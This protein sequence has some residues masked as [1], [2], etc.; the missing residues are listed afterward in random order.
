M[1]DLISERVGGEVVECNDE[2]FAEAINLIKAEE[3]VW[4]EDLY[5]DRGKWMDGWETRR[6]REPGHDWCVISLGIPGRVRRVTVDT[7]FFTGNY[8]EEFSLDVSPGNDVWSELVPRT[9]LEGDARATFEVESPY[10]VAA[11]RLNIYPD[12]GVARL[13]VEGD[14]IPS[15]QIVCPDGPTDL[16]DARLGGEWLEA[17]D[18]HYSPPSNLLMP[19]ESAGMWDG[20]ETRRRRGPG[21]DWATFR[22]GLPGMVDSFLVD[23][24][25]F[26][27]NCPGWVSV[28]LSEDGVDW[29]G[30]VDEAEVRPDTFNELAVGEPTHARFVR[31]SLHPDG[32]VAR[33][34]VLGRP[35]RDA[36]GGL[37]L[38][39]LNSLFEEA[40]RGF[41]FTTCVAKAWVEAMVTGRPYESIDAVL[42]RAAAVFDTLDEDDWLQAFAGHPRIGERGGN[43]ENREQAGTASASREVL[44]DLVD[45][46]RRYEEKFGFTYIVYATGRTATEML[47]IAKERLDNDRSS[48]I[49]AAS[50][51]QRR[52]TETRLRRMLCQEV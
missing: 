33:F 30:A 12:G 11:V 2:F 5:T 35:D 27:G 1:I 18:Y 41:F 6:R 31:L 52:I 45:V 26:K 42:L 43:T 19:T 39:Y 24:R 14:P 34:R 51:E 25:H 28:H 21:H 9:R 40:A 13:R 44:R 4:K 38:L 17:S 37:R 23:T 46:N 20:W 3:P 22:L 8:P 16:I 7:S 47:S 48:E 32:G 15:M 29:A 36:A 10:R 50:A 49:A